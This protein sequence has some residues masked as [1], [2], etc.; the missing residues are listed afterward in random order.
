MTKILVVGGTGFLGF[1]IIKKAKKKNWK[2]TS[3]SLKKPTKKR[4]HKN[5]K[6]IFA[7]VE[8][9]KHLKKKLV[10]NYD[11]VVN[12]GG[13]GQHPDFGKMGDKLF[14]SH[15]IGL[16]NLIK[17]LSKKKI[18]RFVHIGSSAEYGSAKSP[19]L[20]NT[21]CNPKTPYGITKFFCTNFLLKLNQISEFPI[22]ILRLFLVYG[23]NQATNRILPQIIT[24]SLNNKKFPTTL[25][26]QYCDFCFVDDVVNAIFKAL[27]TRR[28]VGKIFNIGTGKP[29]QIK[30]VIKKT[31]NLI[32]SGKPLFGKIKYKK[33]TNMKLYPDISKAKK[34]LKWSSKLN[35][36]EGLNL[37]I[38]SY[39]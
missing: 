36:L 28:A 27:N 23:P 35:F 39:R 12:A 5:V 14:K 11:F 33:N 24:N 34:V 4:F 21:I 13:Y 20:E 18:K 25:G 9:F 22:V 1:H 29:I 2:I 38:N 30:K 10:G 37:T 3:I 8:N 31:V 19:Q 26:N 32:G 7:N 17:I 15:F 6:Y 16:V